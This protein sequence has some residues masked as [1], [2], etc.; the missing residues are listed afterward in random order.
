[1]PN[2]TYLFKT[3][4]ETNDQSIVFGAPNSIF[5]YLKFDIDQDVYQTHVINLIPEDD[6][7]SRVG[8]SSLLQQNIECL[9]NS[10]SLC[11]QLTGVM[12]ALQQVCGSQ[13][14]PEFAGCTNANSKFD[15]T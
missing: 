14:R 3:G 11:H 4:T 5:P 7:L 12:C 8:G 1:M 9:L 6:V 15:S 2:L 10:R 13:G